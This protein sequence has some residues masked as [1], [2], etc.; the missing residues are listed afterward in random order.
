MSRKALSVERPGRPAPSEGSRFHLNGT[1]L[2]DCR[3]VEGLYTIGPAT[4]IQA[5]AS[6]LRSS[7]SPARF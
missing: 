6:L 4:F 3:C 7:R 2:V 5:V 1:L